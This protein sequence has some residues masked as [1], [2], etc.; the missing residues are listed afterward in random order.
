[1]RASGILLHI[2]SLPS[3]YG[4]G[5]L[6]KEAY[7][8]VDFLKR[9]RQRYW[10]I[11]P[12]GPTS[13]G[14]SPYQSY[15]S[16]AGNPYFIDLDLLFKNG[17]LKKSEYRD[18]KWSSRDDR[19]DYGVMYLQRSRV[20]KKAFAR[21]DLEDED[22]RRFCDEEAYW[23][24]DYALFMAIKE[25]YDM[26]CW[27][28]WPK[29]LRDH[30]E[31]ALKRF[32]KRH[33][34]LV[35]YHKVIQYLFFKQWCD[36]K[37]YANEKG[38]AIIGDL[39]IY[40]AYDSVDVWANTKLFRLDEEK[41]PTYVAGVPGDAFNE[42]GQL[43]GNPLYDWSYMQKDD[44]RWWCD[45][46][47][48]QN[49]LYDI[50]RLDHFR[51]F[52]KYFEVSAQEDTA[53]NGRWVDGPGYALFDA[54]KRRYG[55]LDIIAEDLGVITDDVR[56]LLHACGFMGMRVLEFAFDHHTK[57]SSYLPHNLIKD[58]VA[59]IG[60]HDND[61]IEGW[62]KHM[63]R[64]DKKYLIAY[65]RLNKKEGY[66]LGIIKSLWASVADTVII[67]AQD[68]IGASDSRM[69]TPSTVGNWCWRALKGSFDHRLA[70]FIAYNMDIYSRG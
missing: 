41:K 24:R 13:Y 64:E 34:K 25:V 55:D 37:R 63:G 68:L 16:F 23:L 53:R 33:R 40:V 12:L 70:D 35:S 39:P 20:L 3:P 19:V 69:N 11:L 62:L 4:I 49:Y 6:G 30:D 1:M 50:V 36:L 26:K 43:W 54:L 2:S 27:S 7:R 60:T 9:A 21:F 8:F 42:D 38:I 48:Y 28:A 67:Q 59:Y 57:D 47:V 32:E 52:V 65:L 5:T 31:K 58:C 45:R 18:I 46:I 22:Y 17:L 66:R 15:S 56:E 14:D 10:Q 44:Y 29:T 51:G 61:T